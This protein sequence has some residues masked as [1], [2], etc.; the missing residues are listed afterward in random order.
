MNNPLRVLYILRAT[1]VSV[2]GGDTIQAIRTADALRNLGVK[3]DIH[4][5]NDSDIVYAHYD[6]IHFFNIIRPADILPHIKKSGL[7]YVISTIYVDYSY[8]EK[9]DHSIKG[10][11]LNLFGSNT[12]EYLKALAR[13]LFNGEKIRPSQYLFWGHKKSIQTILKNAL[14]LLPNSE[15]EYQ[16]L[17]KN[18][19]IA[20]DYTAVN[21]AAD[22]HL[23]HCTETDIQ[24]KDSKMVLCVARI[25][26]RKNQLNL[27]KA[28]NH[29]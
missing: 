6:F 17:L 27:I 22:T 14:W 26:G 25:E 15:S 10:R 3:I 13:M 4:L 19:G 20:N 21:N 8:Y 29:S 7:P 2:K 28:L 12:R 23:F 16:R 24:N 9:S 5:C 18:Y 11:I 1:L